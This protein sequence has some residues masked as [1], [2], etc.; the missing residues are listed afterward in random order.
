MVMIKA[1]VMG[2]DTKKAMLIENNVDIYDK[3]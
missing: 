3:D 2:D 1:S